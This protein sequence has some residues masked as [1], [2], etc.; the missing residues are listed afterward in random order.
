MTFHCQFDCYRSF[1]N[2]IGLA[3][4]LQYGLTVSIL[5]H[6]VLCYVLTLRLKWGVMGVS[7][8]TMITIFFNM[9][10]VVIYAWR[11]TIHR[12][13]PLPSRPLLYLAKNDVKIY[14]SISLPSIIMLMAEWIGVEMIVAIAAGLSVEAVAA[15]SISY[16]FHNV[17]Y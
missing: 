5:L 4:V 16:S 2:S 15:M 9:L 13:R 1:L 6:L 10:F 17:I 3:R 14:L 12:V 7:F 8:S 11:F